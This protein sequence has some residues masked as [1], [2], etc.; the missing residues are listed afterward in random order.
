MWTQPRAWLSVRLANAKVPH[1]CK[2]G[3]SVQGAVLFWR[4][5]ALLRETRRDLDCTAAFGCQSPDTL[6]EQRVI[7]QV[8]RTLNGA[9]R[10]ARGGAAADPLDRDAQTFTGPVRRHNDTLHDLPN[11]LF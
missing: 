3:L 8:L 10:D 1:Q 5:A 11:H 6:A 7:A 9:G 4:A 2:H